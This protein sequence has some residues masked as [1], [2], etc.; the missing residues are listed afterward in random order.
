MALGLG[1][2]DGLAAGSF[3]D[4]FGRVVS[5]SN[6]HAVAI[7]SVRMGNPLAVFRTTTNDGGHFR[8]KD[9]PAGTYTLTVSACAFQTF[10]ERV[11][12]SGD[13]PAIHLGDIRLF[14]NVVAT[15]PSR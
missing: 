4:V 8:F 6:G 2:A 12:V 5:D 13:K 3:F 9:V 14:P 10:R 15:C 1:T 11:V 7:T